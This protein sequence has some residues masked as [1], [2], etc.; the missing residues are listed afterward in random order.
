[1]KKN[2]LKFIM[3]LSI[4]VFYSC[5]STRS[6]GD[7]SVEGPT[8]PR[9]DV[10][11][12]A[13]QGSVFGPSQEFVGS[14]YE[15]IGTSGLFNV[16]FPET[17][18][19]AVLHNGDDSFAAR[20][21]ALQKASKSVRIQALIF[22]GDE[23]G[24]YIA[25]LLKEKKAQGLDVRVIVDA[26][27]NPGLQTQLMYFD[28][29]ENGIEVEGYESFYLQWLNEMPV[30]SHDAADKT[31]DPNKRYHE[32]MWIIDG[33]TDHGVAVVGGLNI[34]NEYFR[35]DP[36]NPSRYWRDQDVIVKGDVVKDMVATFERNFEY[37][38]KVKESRGILNTN[39][40]WEATRNFLDK[41]G[42]INMRYLTD[43]RLNK[44][45]RELAQKKLDLKFE[46]AKCRFFQNRPRFGE[47]YIEQVYLKSIKGAKS[48]ILIGN[49]YFVASSLF[50]EIIKDAARR[51]VK[52]IILTNSPETNDLPM[53][54]IVGRDY[55]D[56]ILA[57]NNEPVVQSCDGG[58]VQIWEWQGIRNNSTEKTEGTIHAK[59]AVFD[60]RISIVGSYNMDPRS[61]TLNSESAIVFENEVLSRQLKDMFYENDLNFSRQITLE[62]TQAFINPK[63]AIYQLER[64]FG[65][66]IEDDL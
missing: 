17:C 27:S 56:D 6:T 35:I 39:K 60:R 59:Y 28:L 23:S 32:K 15:E 36:Q 19:I 5:T 33:E 47:T 29:K 42:K 13:I 25:E 26:M 11:A 43:E 37:F 49:A 57:V 55:Y 46:R 53:L 44:N 64:E 58:G 51:C 52:V 12:P 14:P 41:T 4:I 54:T 24:L 21:Q 65:I 3:A 7:K 48:E 63:D 30:T 1:M 61:R 2:I 22:T 66:L 10:Q 8:A 34:A 62:D 20:I 9:S 31:T 40:Y 18:R 45:V 50:V 16:H 38:L